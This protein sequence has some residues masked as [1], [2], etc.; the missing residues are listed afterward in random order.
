LAR[1]ILEAEREDDIPSAEIPLRYFQF[2]RSGDFSLIEPVLYHNQED[3]LSLLGVVILGGSFFI[4]EQEELPEGFADAM[5][6]FG[7]AKVLEKTGELARSVDFIRRALEGHLSE[8]I[9][10][11][12]KKK[13]AYYFKR[14]QEWDKAIGLWQEM[15]PLNQLFCFR[16]LAMY[17]EHK[18]KD[19]QKAKET[20]E[21]GLVLA[22]GISRS[23]E[24]D[25]SHRL[26]RLRGK[27][28]RQKKTAPK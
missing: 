19:Y 23:Y 9:S 13:L 7:A 5:D 27:I 12:A 16:E 1:E 17:Y 25:F 4:E 18:G 8:E 26:E 22:A 21:E 28:A 10:L 11:L 15:T 6:L 20:A 3:I 14:N 2:L 24:E